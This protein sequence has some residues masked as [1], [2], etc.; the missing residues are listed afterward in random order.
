MDQVVLP[1]EWCKRLVDEVYPG[2]LSQRIG[3]T[4]SDPKGRP[5]SET[6][7]PLRSAMI[8]VAQMSRPK[9][10]R[11][12]APEALAI[13]LGV[14]PSVFR[15]LSDRDRVRAEAGLSGRFVVGCVARNLFRK[16]IPILIKAFAGFC[17]DHPDVFLYLHMDPDDQG[18]RLLEVLRRYGVADRAAFT[19]GLAGAAGVNDTTLNMIYNLFDVMVLPTM[20]EA[21]GLPLLEAMA[22]GVPVLATDC[23][24]V[25]EL[26]GDRGELVKVK[27]WLTLTWDGAEYAI[28]DG[29]DLAQRLSRLHA[30]GEARAEYGA[31]GRAF[32]LRMTWDHCA[33]RWMALIDRHLAPS[34]PVSEE[35]V[36]CLRTFTVRG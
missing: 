28:A 7:K 4:S 35:G 6:R 29:D 11:Q 2:R 10:K 32:A 19:R 26:V 23:S 31:R 20:G 34:A 15:P 30:D 22:A 1:S 18:W 25:P 24:A 8:P 33:S 27:D 3:L 17:R 5:S 9:T 16:Q 13:P 14:D 12:Q 21:F 36:V